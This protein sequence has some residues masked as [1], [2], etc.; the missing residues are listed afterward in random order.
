[1]E[2]E[3]REFA[4]LFPEVYARFARR[5]EPEEYRPSHE[6]N[7]ILQHLAGSG[8]L[9]V[10]EAAAHF[11]GSQAATSELLNRL[12]ARTRGPHPGRT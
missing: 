2:N 8:P 10:M 12:Q 1:M 5:W 7:A 6:A 4:E 9:T 3:I 11:D